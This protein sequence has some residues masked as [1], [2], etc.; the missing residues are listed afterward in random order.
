MEPSGIP[1]D[2]IN[3]IEEEIAKVCIK[4]RAP[5]SWK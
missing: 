1:Y 4:G 5:E 3:I 2:Y